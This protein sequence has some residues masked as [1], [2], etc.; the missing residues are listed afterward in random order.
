MSAPATLG[1]VLI[2]ASRAPVTVRVER[3]EA[4][5]STSGGGLA[6]GLRALHN[7][8]ENLWIGWPGDTSTLTASARTDLDGRLLRERVVALHLPT[9]EMSQSYGSFASGVLWPLLHYDL[10]RIPADADGWTAYRRAN[11]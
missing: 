4:M 5:L 11:V 1:R 3:G 9:S 10:D 6:P 7:N 2:V 8:P